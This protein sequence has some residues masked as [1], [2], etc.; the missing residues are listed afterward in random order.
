MMEREDFG[1]NVS[2]PDNDNIEDYVETSPTTVLGN[3][4]G[5]LKPGRKYVMT[6]ADGSEVTEDQITKL[7][8]E[9][10]LLEQYEAQVRKAQEKHRE[11]KR[12]EQQRNPVASPPPTE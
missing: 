12:Q 10:G 2:C 1:V 9:W 5:L 7:V 11:L 4:R 8:T 3:L 6:W